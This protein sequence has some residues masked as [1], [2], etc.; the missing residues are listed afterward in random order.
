MTSLDLSTPSLQGAYFFARELA[1]AGKRKEAD[2]LYIRL[3][4]HVRCDQGGFVGLSDRQLEERVA[5]DRIL[6]THD[7]TEI[8]HAMY[9]PGE[10]PKVETSKQV[11]A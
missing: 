5:H 7:I 11:A 1:L 9:E 10:W 6:C 3:L 4:W 2:A 8:T